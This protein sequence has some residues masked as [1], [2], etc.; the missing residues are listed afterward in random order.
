MVG[1]EKMENT[2]KIIQGDITQASVDAIVNAANPQMLGG[3]GVDG[4]IHRAAGPKLLGE[5]E[6]VKVENGVRCPT[7]EARI[8]QAGDLKA[9]YVIH[10]VGPRYGIDKNPEDLL[11]FAYQNCLKLA[12]THGCKS[13]A[14]PAISCGVY[15]YPPHDAA[16]IA[17]SIC[18][19]AEYKLLFK[20]FY[21]FS[22]KMTAI[23]TDLLE[24]LE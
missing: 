14:F 13:I 24:Q 18:K 2:I 20:S 16:K 17:I 7:G 11:A 4:A 10:T 6:K 23:W 21:L 1:F 12:I 9:K 22:D 8:T 19:R 3:G 5:C 15:G